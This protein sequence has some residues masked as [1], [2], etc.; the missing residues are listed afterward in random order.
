M[1]KNL[2]LIVVPCVFIIFLLLGCSD[3]PVDQIQEEFLSAQIDGA[4]FMVDRSVGLISCEKYLND[5]GGIDLQV[6]VE[7]PSGEILEFYI[8]NYMGAKNYIFSNNIFNKNWMRYG[9]TNPLGDWFTFAEN[10]QVQTTFPYLNI[11]EDKGNY[12]KGSFEFQAHNRVDNSM[13]SINNGNFNFKIASEL[14]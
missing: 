8:A 6:K 14:D 1:K 2:K 7:T 10:K 5:Y 13:K 3:D 4:D 12:I 9:I 11:I